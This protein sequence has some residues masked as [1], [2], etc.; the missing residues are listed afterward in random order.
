MS[1]GRRSRDRGYISGN[2]V[3]SAPTYD[4]VVV[5]YLVVAGGG[6]GGAAEGGGGGAGGLKSTITATGG[7]GTLEAPLTLTTSASYSVVVGAGGVSGAINSGGFGQNPGGN[8]NNSIFFTITST[9]GGGGGAG[10][11]GPSGS[12]VGRS[13]GS[14]GGGNRYLSAAGGAGTSNQG[15]AGGAGAA[16]VRGGGGGGA[17]T[18]G[19]SSA[20]GSAGGAGVA[21]LITGS[22]ITYAG[23]GGGGAGA[24][25]AGAGTGGAGG[26]G[27]ASNSETIATAGTANLGGG[28]GGGGGGGTYGGPGGAGGSGVVILRYSNLYTLNIGAGLSY[29]TQTVNDDKVTTFTSGSGSISLSPAPVTTGDYESIATVLV[30]SAGASTVTFSNIPQTYKHLQV[31]LLTKESGTGT[32]G[33]NI[34]ASLNSDTTHTNYRSHYLTGDGAAAAAGSVQ[35]GGYYCLVGNTATSNAGYTS[36]FGVMV[37]DVLDYAN[38]SKYKTL[39]AL[40]GHDR[41]GSGEVGIDSSVWMNTAATTSISFSIA[42]GTNFVQHSHFA[43]YGIRG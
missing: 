15:F 16:G 5:N 6:G 40:W 13:G 23:G 42:G 33:P 24:G 2:R 43:L 30:G 11:Q 25:A 31:R 7:G 18:V 34:V 29:S 1:R 38:T 21:T 4:E 28:G 14:G 26:G 3:T 8:G 17:S 37:L 32:G 39:R 9:G 19:Q 35:A 41:N 12:N 27:T 20:A 22:S 10:D 36:M